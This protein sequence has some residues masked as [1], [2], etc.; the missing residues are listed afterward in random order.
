M[1]R[2]HLT[3]VHSGCD[4][5]DGFLAGVHSSPNVFINAGLGVDS[6]ANF[7][8]DALEIGGEVAWAVGIGLLASCFSSGETE[9]VKI[10]PAPA[11]ADYFVVI[12]DVVRNFECQLSD[13]VLRLFVGVRHSHGEVYKAFG[14][15]S[16]VYNDAYFAPVL[17]KSMLTVRKQSLTSRHPLPSFMTGLAQSLSWVSCVLPHTY[18]RRCWRF[19]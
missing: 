13:I 7:L 1:G 8:L 17:N 11:F 10:E 15:E 3:R 9:Q 6:S 16:V 5:D 4:K 19:L 12:L 18:F 2:P 14:A